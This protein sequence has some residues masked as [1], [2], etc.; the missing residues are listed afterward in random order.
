MNLFILIL[1]GIAFFL[2]TTFAR[3]WKD[4][5]VLIAV[6]IGCA[7]NANLYTTINFPIVVGPFSFSFAPL[8]YCLYMYTIAVAFIDYS[9]KSG[10]VIL[11]T[12]IAAIIISGLI[13]FDAKCS[14]FGEV[15]WDELKYLLFYLANCAGTIVGCVFM[16]LFNKY[17]PIKNKYVM[18]ACM[19]FGACVLHG[20]SYYLG[21][22]MLID[23]YKEIFLPSMLGGLLITVIFMVV[24]LI[25]FFVN[26]KWV[27]P[28]KPK[29]D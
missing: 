11:Y 28:N 8:L 22:L 23:N 17:V 1:C 3:H 2:I 7:C 19:I 9:R 4:K 14:Y 10:R 21:S 20:V 25:C 15:S 24:G 12:S 13:E 26:N 27:K 18:L 16:T 6:A 29:Q 5:A